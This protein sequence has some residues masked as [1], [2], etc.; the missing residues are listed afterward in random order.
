MIEIAYKDGRK[1]TSRGDVVIAAMAR[2]LKVTNL[3]IVVQMSREA[4]ANAHTKTGYVA[5]Y[6]SHYKRLIYV[7]GYK[8]AKAEIYETVAHELGH[9]WHAQYEFK[10]FLKCN[11]VQKEL[12]AH[13]KQTELGYPPQQ[14]DRA[15]YQ[16]KDRRSKRHV[17][18]FQR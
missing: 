1:I 8:R 18:S 3:K 17:R 11:S 6:Y 9:A 7:I 4:Y 16:R 15:Y 14:F 5:G 2:Q 10:D 13:E 12:K